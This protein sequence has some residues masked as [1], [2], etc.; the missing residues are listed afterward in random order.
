MDMAPVFSTLNACWQSEFAKLDLQ[1]VATVRVWEAGLAGLSPS[2]IRDGLAAVTR[3]DEKRRPSPG[4]FRRICMDASAAARRENG[5]RKEQRNAYQE[6]SPRERALAATRTA[7]LHRICA[8]ARIGGVALGRVDAQPRGVAYGTD[9]D[10]EYVA[11]SV[12]LPPPAKATFDETLADQQI[13]WSA[14][15]QLFDR[16]WDRHEGRAA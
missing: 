8:G 3:I 16:E 2:A 4:Q 7:Y 6:R 15:E 11:M 9:F 12:P 5:I 10:W 1:D 14:L 13:A